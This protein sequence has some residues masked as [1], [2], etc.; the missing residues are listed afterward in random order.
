MMLAIAAIVLCHPVS[1]LSAQTRTEY[2]WH[3]ELG[4]VRRW[5][6]LAMGNRAIVDQPSTGT[7]RLAL[8]HVPAGWPYAYQWSGV[9]RDV[10]V[11]IARFPLL[12]ASVVEL[13][14]YAHLDIEVLDAKGKPV[15]GFRASTLQNPGLSTFN[16][17]GLLDPAT[18]HHRLRLIV[19]GPNE[20]CSA[21]Y[22]WVRFMAAQNP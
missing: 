5:Q 2:G 4:G 8:R 10:T 9:T 22:D 19:G 17:R 13:H 21:T 7:M 16:F 18:Y 15:K 6:P 12:Q 1:G 11:D 20:G 3:D 14:G